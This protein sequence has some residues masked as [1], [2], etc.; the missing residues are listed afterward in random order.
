MNLGVIFVAVIASGL[1]GRFAPTTQLPWR[2]IASA[3]IGGLLMGYG[4]RIAF[5]CNI[6]AFFL[7]V[8]DTWSAYRRSG[9]LD[10]SRNGN[11]GRVVL[12]T[13]CAGNRRNARGGCA[14]LSRRRRRDA[15]DARQFSPPDTKRKTARPP[16]GTALRSGLWLDPRPPVD[17]FGKRA[18]AIAFWAV[19]QH[20]GDGILSQN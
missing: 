2:T 16:R 10:R 19:G 7:G 12:R 5:G 13:N 15:A 18:T 20:L 14:I 8:G 1:A 17:D 6:G 11:I 3:V 4:A 9:R